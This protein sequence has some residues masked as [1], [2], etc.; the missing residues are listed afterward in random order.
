MSAELVRTCWQTAAAFG[1]VYSVGWVVLNA[2][3]WLI[4]YARN[5]KGQK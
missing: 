2:P 5:R 1:A 4:T 3:L